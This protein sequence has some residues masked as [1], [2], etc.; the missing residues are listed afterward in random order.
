MLVSRGE[1]LLARSD[2]SSARLFFARAA[3]AGDA[4]AATR[5]AVTYDPDFIAQAHLPVRVDA[6]LAAYW[7]SYGRIKPKESVAPPRFNAARRSGGRVGQ[8]TTARAPGE[9]IGVP[10][11]ARI[12]AP[13]LGPFAGTALSRSASLPWSS[14]FVATGERH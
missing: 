14:D 11:L 7:Y 2:V 10:L 12:L 13:I 9:S 4:H 8:A 1:A 6:A 5:L 3:L